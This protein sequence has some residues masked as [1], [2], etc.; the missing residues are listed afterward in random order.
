VLLKAPDGGGVEWL[1]LL[2]PQAIRNERAKRA[3]SR[4][5]PLRTDIT[6]P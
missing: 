1:T 5:I 6:S 2:L 3:T 4:E